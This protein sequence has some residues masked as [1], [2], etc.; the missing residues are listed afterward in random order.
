VGRGVAT[1]ETIYLGDVPAPSSAERP[2]TVALM[3]N[4]IA[5]EE[6]LGA[7]GTAR[8]RKTRA[9]AIS[10]LPVDAFRL[11]SGEPAIATVYQK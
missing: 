6:F 9:H 10:E 11:S 4:G 1:A 5:D 3:K 7:A 2:L 8:A